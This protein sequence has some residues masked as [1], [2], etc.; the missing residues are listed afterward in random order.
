MAKRATLAEFA[1]AHPTRGSGCWMCTIPER[2]EI[3]EARRNRVQISVIVD[4]LNGEC[5]Y[6][7]KATPNRVSNHLTNH[8]KIRLQ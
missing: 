3:E 4:W 8:A 2:E 6:G 5:G 1:A 7:D